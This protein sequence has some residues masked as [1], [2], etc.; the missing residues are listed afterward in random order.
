[1]ASLKEKGTAFY[2]PTAKEANLWRDG[3]VAVWQEQAK[4]GDGIDKALA[5]RIL[6]EQ[7]MDSFIK[8]LE[9]GGVL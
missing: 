8:V 5:R 1:M 6:G 9:K 2:K 4:V 7:G 3:S